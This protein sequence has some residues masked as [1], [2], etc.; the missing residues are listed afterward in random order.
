MPVVEPKD[1]ALAEFEAL[2]AEMLAIRQTDN[3]TFSVAFTAIAAIGGFALSKQGGRLEVLL[4][5][6]V[7]L[8]GLGLLQAQ[9]SRQ[10][11]QLAAYIRDCLW[12]RLPVNGT[13][14]PSWEHY[15]A[16]SRRFAHGLIA[17]VL[18]FVV[19]SIA[20]LAITIGQWDT[21]LFPLWWG[22][23]LILATLGL[24]GLSALSEKG[25]TLRI[26]GSRKH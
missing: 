5:L 10:I 24:L 9:N 8:S 13:R 7:V 16:G 23:V 26:S 1:V 19:P 14:Y 4:V 25:L 17:R 2:R 15:I 20:S 21:R 12:E 3:L 11:D 18:I 22:D 6:P